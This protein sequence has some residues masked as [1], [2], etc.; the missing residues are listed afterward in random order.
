MH[1]NEAAVVAFRIMRRQAAD[2]AINKSPRVSDLFE[3]SRSSR[4]RVNSVID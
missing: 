3:P 2:F 1:Q 4:Y